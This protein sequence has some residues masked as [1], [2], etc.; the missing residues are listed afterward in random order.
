MAST[1]IENEG[2]AKANRKRVALCF[3]LTATLVTACSGG[4][5]DSASPV[6]PPPEPADP[7]AEEL[8]LR[9]LAEVLEDSASDGGAS[10]ANEAAI[11]EEQLNQIIDL[12]NL[13]SDNNAAYQ[14]AISI[15]TGFSNPPSVA[16]VQTIV[17]SVNAKQIVVQAAD[18]G[19]AS[20]VTLNVLNSIS[21]LTNTTSLPAVYTPLLEQYQ[22]AIAESN[23]TNLAVL[24]QLQELLGNVNQADP[25]GDGLSN[26]E[27]SQ[28]FDIEVNGFT[29]SVLSSPTEADT[30]SDALNDG[31]ELYNVLGSTQSAFNTAVG[32]VDLD[33]ISGSQRDSVL[34]AAYSVPFRSRVGLIDQN[35]DQV[36][37]FTGIPFFDGT[38][39]SS[40]STNPTL[41][42]SDGDTF[43]DAAES[44]VQLTFSKYR[45]FDTATAMNVLG[46]L[47]PADS[48]SSIAPTVNTTAGAYVFEAD[49]EADNDG[50]GKPDIEEWWAGTSVND[51]NDDTFYEGC[52]DA[53]LPSPSGNIGGCTLTDKWQTLSNA[54][55][56]YVPGGLDVN[57]D[58][59]QEPGFWVSQFEAKNGGPAAADPSTSEGGNSI[60]H[61][62]N[63][64]F[65]V[66][67]ITT[68][69]FDGVLCTNGGHDADTNGDGVTT[70][71]T[72]PAGC[73]TSEYNNIGWGSSDAATASAGGLSTPRAVFSA[74]GLP[75]VSESV[76]EARI[77]LLDSAISGAVSYELDLP[78]SIQ[79]QQIV[80]IS[81]HDERNWTN[82]NGD[83][84]ASS[85][86]G[87][88]V[89]GHTD[90]ENSNGI[91]GSA[92]PVTT[93][94]PDDFSQGYDGTGDG[95]EFASSPD[96]VNQLGQRRTHVLRNGVIARDFNVPLS[97]EI[98]LWDLAGNVWNWTKDLVAARVE[99]SDDQMTVGGDRFLG[100]ASEWV[101][102]TSMAV[103]DSALPEWWKPK[104]FHL[105]N[106][107]LDTSNGAGA[108]YDGQRSTGAVRNIDGPFVRTS[109][110]AAVRRGGQWSNSNSILETGLGTTVLHSGPDDRRTG[111]GFRAVAQ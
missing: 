64:H 5:A 99:V 18:S 77:S 43:H 88:L 2:L 25:D 89:R 51:S 57:D 107:I 1:S 40:V 104:L 45:N 74:A 39:W 3:A 19:D 23:G 100:G 9:G 28:G 14:L 11:S 96:S 90:N 85:L 53:G 44:G 65:Q 4:G 49:L 91:T 78:N 108:Y 24:T 62:L 12:E 15:E 38:S 13:I 29:V 81:I 93:A 41:N 34:A 72:I 111:I 61:L 35:G 21:N 52:V 63:A 92:L 79:W 67:S 10:N 48:T 71:G 109:D 76:I 110:F 87:E 97:H 83:G 106:S 80:A 46:R 30:D 32:D 33:G 16:E 82:P 56:R 73:R 101:E 7:T 66:Y 95:S 105:E 84:L 22:S 50:G 8:S 54:N 75:L 31:Y 59:I 47:N 86:D 103:A 20:N 26:G 17:D 70:P 55:F 27:E 37:R 60:A 42:D 58:D 68:E 94:T 36:P 69:Q 98:V 6:L 102:F